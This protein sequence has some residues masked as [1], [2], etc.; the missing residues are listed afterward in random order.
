MLNADRKVMYM[1]AI[2]DNVYEPESVEVKYLE[3]ALEALIAGKP[4]TTTT[5]KA[6]GCSIKAK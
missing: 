1:G 4:I 5:T 6:I 2:D 3:N